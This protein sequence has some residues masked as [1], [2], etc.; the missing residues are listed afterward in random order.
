MFRWIW[1]PSSKTR[2]PFEISFGT[3]IYRLLDIQFSYPTERESVDIVYR[4]PATAESDPII[5]HPPLSGNEFI[6]LRSP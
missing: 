4:P 3:M 1:T 5:P 6:D 2:I